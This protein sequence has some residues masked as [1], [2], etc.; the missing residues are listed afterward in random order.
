M[1]STESRIPNPKLP[2]RA[3]RFFIVGRAE[4]LPEGAGAIIELDTGAELALFNVAGCL[5]AIENFCPHR[6]A[7][8]ADGELCDHTVA[9]AL[10]GWQFDLRTGACLTEAES[11]IET[12]EVVV[13]NG[14][15]KIKV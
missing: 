6:G 4:D 14:D 7:S 13:E 9:C 12:Y 8:L 2:E 5:Y 15:I 1:S 10:H 11:D 3:N